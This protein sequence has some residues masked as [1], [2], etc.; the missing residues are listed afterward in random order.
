MF[1]SSFGFDQSSS[2]APAING[3]CGGDIIS[4]LLLL[5]LGRRDRLGGRAGG[6]SSPMVRLEMAPLKEVEF[7][8]NVAVVD[9]DDNE[10]VPL[11]YADG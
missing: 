1:F 6:F 11:P 5:L 10:G 8:E 9:D 2:F 4:H 3:L 7:E